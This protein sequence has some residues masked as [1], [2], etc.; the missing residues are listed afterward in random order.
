MW[1]HA[2]RWLDR[3]RGMPFER[4]LD[5]E[6]AA[7][8]ELAEADYR[9]TGM[10]LAEARREA[11]LA[12]GG[13]AQTRDAVR[14]AHGAW[15]DAAWRDVRYAG[16]QLRRAPGFMVV[17]LLS[18]S[19]GSG[20]TIAV[21]GF[22]SALLFKPLEAHDPS[23]LIRMTGQGGDTSLALATQSEAHIPAQDYFRYRDENQSFAALAAHFVGG[24]ERVRVDGPARVIPVTLVSGN[25]FETLGVR[26]RLG[27]ALTPTDAHSGAVEAVVLSDA[28]WR[29]FFDSDPAI[30]G[31]TA[32]IEGAPA[33]IVG[34]LSPS[35]TGTIG[36][37]L[38]QMYAPILEL[39]STVYRV[40][41]IG[42]LRDGVSAPQAAADLTRI[43]RQL[44]AQDGR[45]RGIETYPASALQPLMGRAIG[46]VSSL[47]FV[48]VGVVLLV[49]CDNI[50][51]L[52]LTRSAKRRHEIGVRLALGASRSRLLAQMIVES[53]LLCTVGGFVGLLLATAAARYL[54][55]FYAPVPMPFALRYDL[56]WRV[57]AFALALSWAAT[58]LCGVAPARHALKTDVVSALRMSGLPGSPR[59]RASLIVTQVT[60]STALLVVGVLL[61]RSL[62]EPIA[63]GSGFVSRGVLMTTIGLES[64]YT[65]ARFTSFIRAIVSSLEQAPGISSVTSADNVPLTNNRPITPIEMQAD[66]RV[67]PVYANS[68]APSLFTTLGIS[69]V[70]GRDFTARD[71]EASSPVGIVNETL[72]Q[73]FWPGA[74]PIGRLLYGPDGVVVQVV[75]L[76]RDAKYE[77]AQEAPKAFL[78]RPMAQVPV[79]SPTLLIRTTSDPSGVF[80]LIRARVAELD[81]DLVPFNL[82]TL[83]DRLGLGTIVNRTAATTAGSMG[84]MALLLSVMGVYGTMAY[85]GQQRRREIG[86]RLALGASRWSVVSL[87]TRQGMIWSSVGLALGT[88]AG[89]AAALILRSV[90]RGVTLADPIA[91][92]LTPL[93]LGGA[94]YAACYW[95]ARR[96][97]DLDP[98]V[99]LREE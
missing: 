73:R 36:P 24:P 18:L 21:F 62:A 63:S 52:L 98:L 47:F 12:L 9:A 53:L 61:A 94:A 1:T 78:Y 16:R 13:T 33:T 74:S 39:P 22:A 65:P 64:G 34:V 60:L 85:L 31:R 7:H 92:V 8:L 20:A 87:M 10:T 32:F 17:A 57:E 37:M 41:L 89:L 70:A 3:L 79:S 50:A 69:L 55:Q 30:V 23:R 28:G 68:V 82:M 66:D 25:Y 2:R 93:I 44:T 84:V 71:D 91:F 95:P 19:I 72:A 46:L 76:A 26:A 96:A 99:A 59:L 14:D 35:F 45:Q 5:D 97:A 51:L 90:L 58:L 48:I 56:D 77:S 6:L 29:R 42:R 81:P 43:A 38:P 83:D 80:A 4:E 67:G 27:R 86:V 54:T 40:D 49:A 88:S 11:R 15:F 75:G